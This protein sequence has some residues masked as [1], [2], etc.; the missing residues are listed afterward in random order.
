MHRWAEWMVLYA[1]KQKYF[2]LLATNLAFWTSYF[3]PEQTGAV[4]SSIH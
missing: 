2:G 3:S 4:F 1:F